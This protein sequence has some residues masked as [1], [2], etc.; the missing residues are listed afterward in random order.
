M[1]TDCGDHTH[2]ITRLPGGSLLYRCL[3]CDTLFV[4]PALSE[5]ETPR[6]WYER[7]VGWLMEEM[8]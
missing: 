5:P 7:L 2:A 6:A 8:K 1:T 3:Q 4:A